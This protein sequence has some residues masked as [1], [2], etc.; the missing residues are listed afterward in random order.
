M[1]YGENRHCIEEP[2]ADKY[3][4]EA[5]RACGV[6]DNPDRVELMP[7]CKRYP[8]LAFSIPRQMHDLDKVEAL[9]KLAY[10]KGKMDNR[11]AVALMLKELI[12]I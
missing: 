11:N 9:M 4:F 5:S 10:E 6:K 8:S 1:D 7:H 3:Y 2:W 12:A